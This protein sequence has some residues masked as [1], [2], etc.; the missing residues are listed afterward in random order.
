MSTRRTSWRVK[1]TFEKE[2]SLQF[3]NMLVGQNT[4]KR[5]MNPWVEFSF[6]FTLF[7]LW[8]SQRNSGKDFFSNTFSCVRHL[9]EFSISRNQDNRSSSFQTPTRRKGSK[10]LILK[11]N[12][13]TKN[14]SRQSLQR[15]Q[16]NIQH[17]STKITKEQQ[18]WHYSKSGDSNSQDAFYFSYVSTL[19]KNSLKS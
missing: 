7:Y 15:V 6:T 8:T 5:G 17:V 13:L 18:Y 12:S 2:G 4:P 3:S 10:I 19:L 9:C 11:E 1:H 14:W 16:R